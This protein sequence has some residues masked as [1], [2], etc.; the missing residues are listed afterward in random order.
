[1]SLK[2]WLSSSEWLIECSTVAAILREYLF[3]RNF[4]EVIWLDLK[5]LPSTCATFVN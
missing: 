5:Q 4:K 1:M 3:L 2:S